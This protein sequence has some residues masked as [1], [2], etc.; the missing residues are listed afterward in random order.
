MKIIVRC[1]VKDVSEESTFANFEIGSFTLTYCRR[2]WR[3][4][5]C[6]MSYKKTVILETVIVSI[7]VTVL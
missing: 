5:G 2:G 3:P 4:S 6:M 7:V 1:L